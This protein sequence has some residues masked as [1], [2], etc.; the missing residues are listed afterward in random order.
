M[1]MLNRHIISFFAENPAA[2]AVK[3]LAVLTFS[4][5]PI[6][7]IADAGGGAQTSLLLVAVI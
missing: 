1:L 5:F 6:G 3:L 7:V 2:S 4:I